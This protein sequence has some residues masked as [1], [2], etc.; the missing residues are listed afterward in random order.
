MIRIAQQ[1]AWLSTVFRVPEDGRLTC[2]EFALYATKE[3]CIF[4]LTPLRLRDIRGN[5]AACWHPLFANGVIAYGFPIPP[6]DGEIGVEIPFEA[7]I[8][9]ADIIGPVEYRGGLLLKGYSTMIFPKPLPSLS[10]GAGQKSAQWHL[11]YQTDDTLAMLSSVAQHGTRML[12]PLDQLDT[13]VNART[14]LGCYKE[15]QVH[16]GTDTAAYDR[17]SSS[18]AKVLR[19]KFE[20]SGFTLS[21]SLPKIGGPSAA[22]SFTLPKRLSLART[23][24]SYE[25][26]LSYSMKMPIVL[27]D[28]SD[29]RA[30][31]VPALGVIL[32][33]IHVWGFLRKTDLTTSYIPN[34]PF[35]TAQWD[36]GRA[37]QEVIYK[38]SDLELYRSKDNNEPYTL[39]HLVKKFWLEFEM[40][41]AAEK[42]HGLSETD[43]LVG[44]ELMEI[45]NRDPYSAPK[46][47]STKAF[48]GNWKC[49]A[50]DPNMIILF[51]QGLGDIIV[52]NT[53]AQKICKAWQ[54]VPKGNDYLTASTNCV[55]QCSKRFSGPENCSQ[56][57][58][59]AFWKRG[60]QD[61]LFADCVHDEQLPCQ[62]LQQLVKNLSLKVGDT[63]QAIDNLE[64]RGAVTF[65][66]DR[67]KKQKLQ[68]KS[69]Q[70]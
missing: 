49:L 59:A 34:L 31:M 45:I 33:M 7:M 42:D 10:P 16:L 46:E 48:K 11:V 14:F 58:R 24:D 55:V 13:L 62:R 65:G 53:D 6:R 52:P 20:L 54:S 28:T 30:W 56:L 37:A 18:N 17:I 27:Y 69:I 32:H 44:W 39:K 22:A 70:L 47:P 64:R 43:S 36:I 35:T 66:H 15:I 19:R 29:R 23:E 1:L 5:S 25:Q 41:I 68:K 38:H 8:E 60:D 2:S 51:C 61:A 9:L 26:V 57:S 4:Q 3:S 40:I 63:L 50:N 21:F 12:C 67:Q